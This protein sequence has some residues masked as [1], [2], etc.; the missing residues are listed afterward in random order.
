MIPAIRSRPKTAAR[1]AAKG[2]LTAAG[3]S[4]KLKLI[5]SWAYGS[6]LRRITTL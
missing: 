4:R 2:T 1:E 6:P 3:G 5:S